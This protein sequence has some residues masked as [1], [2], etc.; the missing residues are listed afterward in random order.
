MTKKLKLYPEILKQVDYNPL[1]PIL[2][3][4]GQNA[5]LQKGL[6]LTH[7]MALGLLSPHGNFCFTTTH[8][9]PNTYL[10]KRP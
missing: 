3:Q 8:R 5:P 10:Y 4:K 9:H 6:L 2:F 1:D 7:S